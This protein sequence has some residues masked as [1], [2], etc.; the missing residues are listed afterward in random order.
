MTNRCWMCQWVVRNNYYSENEWEYTCSDCYEESKRDKTN[1]Y[2]GEVQRAKRKAKR[3]DEESK[4]M[5]SY[6]EIMEEF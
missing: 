4:V 2:Y 5:W 3:L 6:E 1:D